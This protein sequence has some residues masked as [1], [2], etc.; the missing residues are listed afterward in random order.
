MSKLCRQVS[1]ESPGP[2]LKE[3][4]FSFDVPVP[5]VPMYGARIRVVYAGACYRANRTRSAS[6]CSTSSVGSIGSITGELETFGI[7]SSTPAHIGIRDGAL[8]P[9][10]EVAGVVDAVGK[11]A[12]RTDDIKEGTRIVLYPYEGVPHGYAEYIV[13]PDFKCLVRV[14]DELPLSVAAML[15]T[16]ALLAMNTVYTASECLK[17]VLEGPDHKDK[18]KVLIV[19]TG[20]LALWA[21]RIATHYFKHGKYHER[22]S[23][24]VATLKDEG[25]VLARECEEVNVVQWTEDLYEKQL[26]ER[27]TDACGGPVDVVLNFGTTSRSLHRSLQCLATGGVALVTEDVGEKLLPKFSKKA[28]QMNVNVVVV[29]NGSIEQ[30]KE[31]VGLVAR[32]E[33]EPPPHSVFPAEEAQEVVRKLC[34]SEI[35]G[36]A[37]LKFQNID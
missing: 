9:G 33:I 21:L 11:A 28:E 1:I 13:V 27:T 29:P 36:R 17:R 31:L 20:G 8:F 12:E 34:N 25:F 35:K 22:I 18:A 26:I 6:V 5:D 4:V 10:Y 3:C 19:G 30:L 32:G 2:T 24:S 37:I 7:H 14:P 23:I 15:P 16:G